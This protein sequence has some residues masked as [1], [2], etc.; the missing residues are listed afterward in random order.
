MLQFKILV[1]GG[2]GFIGSHVCDALLEEGAVVHCLDNLSTGHEGNIH[3]LEGRTDFRFTRADI[4]DKVAVELAMKG[5]A[6]VVHLAALGSVPRSIE[7]PIESESVNLGGFLNVLETARKLKIKRVVFASSSSV[8]G[9]C[10]KLPKREGR[11]GAPL[12]PY[13]VTKLMDE[14]YADLYH[15][16]FGLETIGLRFFNIFGER[17][18]PEGP[19][20]AAIP[21]FVRAL[22]HGNA[23]VI[24][25]DGL[26]SRDFTYVG[27]AVQ[28][29]VRAL[30]ANADQD[31]QVFNVAC[32]ECCTVLDLVGKLKERLLRIDP[33]IPD[34]GVKHGP[35]RAGDVRTSLADIS[36]A[37]ELLG[38]DPRYS[39][40][41]GLDKAVPWY[42][43]HW[44]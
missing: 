31:G 44:K 21:R 25:G 6:A 24:N 2:A 4:R 17:Q 38:Y 26:Q 9:D 3:H 7:H 18:D 28:A 13:A 35:E 5:V 39:L 19:Y 42:A 1:T 23:P 43:E 22:L 11:E 29:V 20:A 15:R 37:R 16:L 14:T 10:N 27:N 36:K 32:G 12:S 40:E 41:Q 34:V 8:Y 33:S 30:E